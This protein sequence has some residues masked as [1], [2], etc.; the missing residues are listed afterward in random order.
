MKVAVI[1]HSG[2]SLGGGLAELRE[3]LARRGVDEPLWR[4]VS[5]SRKAPKRVRR[6][7]E[8]GADVIF[9]WGGDGMAQRSIHAAAGGR[10]AIALL[11][12]GTANL[13]ASNLGIPKD[14]AAAVDIGL[15]GERRRLDVG[16]VN[17]EA[18]TV[19]AGA[20]FDARMIADAD[21][22]L[23]DRFGRLA[24]IWTGVKN[25]RAKP[26]DATIDVDGNRW[27]KGRA[28]C[29]LVG[30][31]GEV[32]G[33]VEIFEGSRADDGMLEVGVLTAEGPI[34]LARTVARVAVGST[35]KAPYAQTTR[36]R[37]MRIKMGKKVPY[38]LDGGDRKKVTKLRVD[39]EP[40]AIEICVPAGKLL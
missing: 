16:R 4:E 7:V 40:G 36:G 29:V 14:I 24:Y 13:L 34:T 30:N 5:K 28:T 21:G 31:F 39:V 25:M 6:A 35:D 3:V 19:M 20:G 26:F 17:G 23:K 11:P 27:F 15:S 12:A 22:A 8:W 33:G 18:F 9:V 10:A 1:A 2:K 37:A 38:E 32:F